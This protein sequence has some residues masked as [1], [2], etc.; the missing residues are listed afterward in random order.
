MS[1]RLVGLGCIAMSEEP[2]VIR[3]SPTDA[4]VIV[5]EAK[6]KRRNKALFA[7]GLMLIGLVLLAVSFGFLFGTIWA[8]CAIIGAVVL[9]IGVLLGT[10]G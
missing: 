10:N 5:D 4:K 9:T 6:A 3:L 1:T 8:S 2:R 7:I